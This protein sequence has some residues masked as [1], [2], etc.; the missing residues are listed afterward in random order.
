GVGLAQGDV[1][2]TRLR[3]L[4][5]A[6]AL[7]ADLVLEASPHQDAA[8]NVHTAASWADPATDPCRGRTGGK[9]S[10][11][12]TDSGDSSGSC[13]CEAATPRGTGLGAYALAFSGVALMIR[14]MRRRRR[15]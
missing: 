6:A 5:P 14:A 13:V 4:L 15:T 9:S 7:G 2:V 10:A 1:W 8:S 12:S 3:A 11:T